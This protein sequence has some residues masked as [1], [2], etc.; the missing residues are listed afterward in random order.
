MK[1]RKLEEKY[2]SV[3]E[4]IQIYQNERDTLS[5]DIIESRKQLSAKNEELARTRSDF[6]REMTRASQDFETKT[7][8]LKE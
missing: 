8:D 6:N 3:S 1:T 2:N 7:I 4:K 5:Q